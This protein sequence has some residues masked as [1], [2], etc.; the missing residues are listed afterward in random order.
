[1]KR[2]KKHSI[3]QVM[4][5]FLLGLVVMLGFVNPMQA[6]DNAAPAKNITLTIG[7]ADMI[8]DDETVSI[9]DAVPVSNN[10]RVFIPLRAVAE[11]FGAEVDFD[12]QT[13]D[14]TITSGKTSVVMNT[15][16]S[17]YTVN[18]ELGW[19]DIAPYVNDDS[20]T[21]VPV[22]FVST[23]LGYDIDLKADNTTIVITNKNA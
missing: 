15:Y 2:L 17:L 6:A 20:R 5:A 19:M 8:V 1:M 3:K 21:M 11:A 12:S 18:G 14:V 13:F 4:A 9:D 16:A 23:A 22:R 7:S 10:D